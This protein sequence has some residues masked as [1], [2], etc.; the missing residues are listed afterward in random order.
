MNEGDY[1]YLYSQPVWGVVDRMLRCR[2]CDQIIFQAFQKN[3]GWVARSV[4]EHIEVRMPPYRYQ[5]VVVQDTV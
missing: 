1:I 2:S 5:E 4:C 3:M